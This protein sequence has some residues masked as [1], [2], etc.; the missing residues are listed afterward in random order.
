M[1]CLWR[2]LITCYRRKK[3]GR[4]PPTRLLATY[5]G[6]VRRELGAPLGQLRDRRVQYANREDYAPRM[7]QVLDRVEHGVVESEQLARAVP[8]ALAP[9][10][11]INQGE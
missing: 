1:W 3:S 2:I 6:V 7:V 4:E 9:E 8:H 10:R 11:G 5:G